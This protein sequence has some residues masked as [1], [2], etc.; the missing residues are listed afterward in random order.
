MNES[1][2]QHHRERLNG[3]MQH[4][5][6]AGQ[7][8]AVL[9]L[10][11]FPDLWRT[12]RAQMTAVVD[13]GYMAIAPDLRGFGD[14]EGPDDPKEYTGVDVLGDLLAILDHL[15]IEQVTLVAHDWGAVGGWVAAQLRPDRFTGIVALSIP[16]TPRGDRSLP[17]ILKEEAPPDYY[18]P[19]FLVPGPSDEEFNADPTEFLRR[20]FYTNS[21]E[22]PG[23]EPAMRTVGGSLLAGLDEPPGELQL[24]P[25][26]ELALYSEAFRKAGATPA[27]NSYRSL[28]RNWELMAA[29]ADSV[30]AVP[31]VT[32]IGEKDLV[33][34]MPGLR[35]VLDL[36]TS[37]LPAGRPTIWIKECG[38]FAQLE[39][40]DEVSRHVLEFLRETRPI[41]GARS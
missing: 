34:G 27:L 30:P 26:S 8:K 32:I 41:D 4:F 40:P 10:H 19:W 36:Q 33:V 14:T 20:I 12:W 31:A 35:E 29:W 7:G 17:D 6:T 3:R 21:A 1:I 5:V 38:H 24:L 28:H 11:G 9:F 25:D 2:F 39:K 22:R 13:A 18:L 37:W 16:W 15:A 23:R